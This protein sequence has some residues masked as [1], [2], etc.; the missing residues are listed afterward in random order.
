[1]NLALRDEL[2]EAERLVEVE[3]GNALDNY[4]RWAE[5]IA[6]S[7]AQNAMPDGWRDILSDISGFDPRGGR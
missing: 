4:N 1:M 2:D 7:K 5:A 6:K 3:R